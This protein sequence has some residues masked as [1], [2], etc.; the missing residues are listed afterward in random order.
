MATSNTTAF[1]YYEDNGSRT[2]GY[3]K[4]IDQDWPTPI[5]IYPEDET[6][7][8]PVRKITYDAKSA[9][10]K[11]LSNYRKCSLNTHKISKD[12]RHRKIRNYIPQE[13]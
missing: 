10:S 8:I 7:E 5:I 3:L 4:V 13:K 11:F 6:A 9:F 1:D 12:H 2:N